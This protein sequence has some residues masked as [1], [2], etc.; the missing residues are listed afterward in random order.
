MTIG[1]KLTISFSAMLVLTL[2]L[3][4]T[5]LSVVGRL[6]SEL[7]KAVNSTG[8]AVEQMGQLT[9]ALAEM[10]AA[11]AGFILFSSLNDAAQ[12]ETQKRKFR[13][14]AAQIRKSIEEVGPVLRGSSLGALQT[15]ASGSS[16]QVSFFDRMVQA[17]AEQKCNEALDLHNQKVL[18]LN[19]EME[20]TATQLSRSQRD[21]AAAATRASAGK[22]S[23]SYWF[24]SIL[25]ATCFGVGV[26]IYFVLRGITNR[27][28]R[29]AGGMGLSA[30]QI[31]AAAFQVS[32]SSQ[33]LA[34]RA[35]EQ[36][37]SLQQSSG[38]TEEISSMTKSNAEKTSAAAALV[39]EGERSVAEAN[40]TLDRMIGSMREISASSDKISRIIKV[41]EEI[42]FQT[43]ILALNAAVEAARAGEAGMGFAVVADEVRNLAQRASHAAQDTTALI[44]ESIA[45]STEGSA[46]LELVSK[47]IRK[48]TDSSQRIKTLVDEVSRSSQEQARGIERV[49]KTAAQMTEV[50]RQTAANA[51]ESA[52]AAE[53]MSAQTRA[54]QEMILEL[55][56]LVEGA[57]AGG[58]GGSVQHPNARWQP[59]HQS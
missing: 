17:C 6:G 38:A 51:E 54:M 47:A 35:S 44:E 55:R 11:E 59:A 36:A 43:N 1:K 24:A 57:E 8:K 48:I 13:E 25:V 41:I 50:T 32:S 52:S 4:Y 26:V 5:S 7:D 46:N 18:A 56:K 29:F 15:L 42:A 10:K 33:S 39:Q 12:V 31:A 3:S 58:R 21:A 20:R 34:Q 14:A 40:Q 16:T 37:A 22:V 28:R 23:S 45:R 53:E 30:E 9:T 49:S 27:L 19:V 2:I